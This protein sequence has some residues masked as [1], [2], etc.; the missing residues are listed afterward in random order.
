M[1]SEMCIRDRLS[2]WDSSGG[3]AVNSAA[4]GVAGLPLLLVRCR[5]V[6]FVR[7]VSFAVA[8]APLSDTAQ[9][10]SEVGFRVSS[11]QKQRNHDGKEIH[12]FQR[13]FTS[14]TF[15]SLFLAVFHL[16]FSGRKENIIKIEKRQL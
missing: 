13:Y 6:F 9:R 3:T 16:F 5:L 14:F 4:A 12:F 8:P 11:R 2:S 1:G 10:V 15:N 7:L